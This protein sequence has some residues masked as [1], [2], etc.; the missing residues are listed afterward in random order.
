MRNEGRL[1]FTCKVFV[2]AML[3]LFLPKFV[4]AERIQ[5]NHASTG[6]KNRDGSL[7][8]DAF[9]EDMDRIPN[10]YYIYVKYNFEATTFN[11][12]VLMKWGPG[13]EFVLNNDHDVEFTYF[14]A[15][16]GA[17]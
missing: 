9:Y 7:D 5:N 12:S 3:I 6:Y 8:W 2:I 11:E 4:E 1:K 16:L 17:F 14:I 10:D 13:A 15:D